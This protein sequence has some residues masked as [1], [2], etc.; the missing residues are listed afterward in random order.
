MNEI[1][2]WGHMLPENLEFDH[3][4]KKV[5]TR[6]ARNLYGFQMARSTFEATRK[7][8]AGK[9]PFN[10]TRSG[11]SGV[12]RY[13]AVWTGD[14]V[15][16]DE[17]MML[18]I[19]IVNSLGL[20]GVAFT[21]YDV[22]GFVGEASTKLFAR[23]ISIGAF[24]PF[25]RGHTMINTKDSEPWSFGEEV[26]QISRNYI[27]FRYQ[28][29]PYIYSLF[30][31]AYQTGKPVQRSLALDH[32]HDPRVYNGQ[33]QHQFLL[34]PFIMVAPVESSKE[35]VKIFFPSGDWYYL[36]DGRKYS[37]DQEVI[38]ESPIHKL[39]VYIKAGA[40]LPMQR[41]VQNTKEVIDELRLHIYRGSTDTQ[42]EFYEDDG[43]TY[44]HESGSFAKRIIYYYPSTHKIILENQNGNFVSSLKNVK[45]L[46]HGFEDMT[47]INVN[48]QSKNCQQVTHSYFIPLEKY[49][50]INDPDSMG[51]EEIIVSEFSYSA[52]RI[53]ISW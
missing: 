51:E 39:P 3:D 26:E 47:Q 29:L 42:F 45:L 34:G 37:G 4:G 27:R 10:L 13:A 5:T 40:I 11:Y 48:G 7:L 22:G 15:S 44:E 43:S 50:P 2:T 1:A 38:V 8:L 31:E 6:H 36:F 14:N 19:R 53:E 17:H 18:G 12:Q 16:Y 46:L 21:G 20:T 41:P 25:F 30:F 32:A 35:F 24:S 28:A 33:F 52:E 23:W 49:D 9:R